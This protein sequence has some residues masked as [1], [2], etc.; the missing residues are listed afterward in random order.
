MTPRTLCI[1]QDTKENHGSDRRRRLGQW[2]DAVAGTVWR[3]GTGRPAR[4][5]T[6]RKE[7]LG[8]IARI[9]T[10]ASRRSPAQAIELAKSRAASELLPI[11]A[12][13][14][15]FTPEQAVPESRNPLPVCDYP[16]FALTALNSSFQSVPIAQRWFSVRM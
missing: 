6:W 16:G 15:W 2:I 10:S 14:Q 4:W 12:S 8:A 11:P 5:K 9:R 7:G 13:L 3:G 1:R